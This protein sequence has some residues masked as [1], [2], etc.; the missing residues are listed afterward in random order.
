MSQFEEPSYA[1]IKKAFVS[2]DYIIVLFE[3]EDAVKFQLTNSK[4]KDVIRINT[5]DFNSHEVIINADS[6][7]LIY[8]WDNIRYLTSV[9]YKKYM[10]EVGLNWAAQ[11]GERLKAIRINKNL[12]IDDLYERAEVTEEMWIRIEEGSYGLTVNF[13]L[14]RKMLNAMD[15][16]IKDFITPQK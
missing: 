8:P 14:L 15:Y 13:E 7:N 3:N 11:I 6:D 2:E 9:D 16:N 12:A 4:T 10:D 1:N 5:V